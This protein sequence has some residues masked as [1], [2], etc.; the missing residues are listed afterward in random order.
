MDEGGSGSDRV[1]GLV[2][3]CPVSRALRELSDDLVD[4]RRGCRPFLSLKQVMLE[5][6]STIWSSYMKQYLYIEDE[7]TEL[8]STFFERMAEVILQQNV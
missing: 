3:P 1:S 7:S 6:I 8:E 2:S 4:S 5:D